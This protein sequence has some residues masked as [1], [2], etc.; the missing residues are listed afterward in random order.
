MDAH[1]T[2]DLSHLTCIS[3]QR[4]KGDDV[5]R[6]P[7]H[8]GPHEALPELAPKPIGWGS[9]ENE[10]DTYFFLYAFHEMIDDVPDVS[11]FSAMLAQLHKNG[12]SPSGEFGSPY[13]HT[14]VDSHRIQQSVIHGRKALHV[15]Y[16]ESS[17]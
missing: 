7:C 17:S 4:W 5:W 15:A 12:V 8:D 9:Y 2:P 14:R 3:G 11:T 1:R 16:G 13:P 6:I 10:T